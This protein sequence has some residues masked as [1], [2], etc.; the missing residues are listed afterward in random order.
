MAGD[1][2]RTEHVFIL[3]GSQTG[4]SE[5]AAED[6]SKQIVEKF[7]PAYFKDLGLT[8]VKVETTCLQLDDF[9]DYRHAAFTKTMV[10]F[11]SS[12]GVGQAPMGAHKF[13]TFAEELLSHT[14]SGKVKDMLKGLK[15][16]LCGLGK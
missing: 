7:T 1:S 14:E 16:A 8:P 5:Q 4:N 10:I 13:R 9:L 12:Y 15:Y 3:Y 6:F 2:I 11:V